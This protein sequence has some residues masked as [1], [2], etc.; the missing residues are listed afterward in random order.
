VTIQ[1]VPVGSLSPAWY[2]WGL[3]CAGLRLAVATP[4]VASAMIHLENPYRFLVAVQH[5][6]LLPFAAAAVI[7]VILPWLQLFVGVAII[8]LPSHRRSSVLIGFF[9]YLG[10]TI[11]QSLAI[12]Q[13]LEI[14][15]GCF[16]SSRDQ[17]GAWS[18]TLAAS[19]AVLSLLL[20]CLLARSVP[21]SRHA[22]GQPLWTGATLAEVLVIL[23]ILALLS[24]L[25][26]SGVQRVRASAD[27]SACQSRLM[28]VG[29]AIHLYQQ[30]WSHFPAGWSDTVDSRQRR[31]LGWTARILPYLE[32]EALDAKIAMAFN[33]YSGDDWSVDPLHLE[34]LANRIPVLTCPADKRLLEPGLY[35][36]LK[37][38]C[39]SFLGVEGISQYSKDGMLFVDSHVRSA[40]IR[41]GLI[42]TLLAGERPPPANYQFGWWY[43]GTGAADSGTMEMTL[44]VAMRN[45]YLSDCPPEIAMFGPDQLNSTAQY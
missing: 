33:S 7:A 9:L 43:R 32:Q 19:G 17:I 5:Y 13:K 38:A 30:N 10:F 21:T 15:C 16:G 24:G 39:T 18:I 42:N 40:E 25:V 26:L 45:D 27:R 2:T 1:T 12:F 31:H 23:A 35:Q 28:Q 3:L 11:V 36:E 34:I 22:S 44:A 6:Q 20:C 8:I 4:L 29:L 41:D 14:S 37:V